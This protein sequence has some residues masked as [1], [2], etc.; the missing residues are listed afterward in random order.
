MRAQQAS[1]SSDRPQGVLTR[2]ARG[3]KLVWGA[4]AAVVGLVGGVLGAAAAWPPWLWPRHLPEPRVYVTAKGVVSGEW[5]APFGADAVPR[6]PSA[7]SSCSQQMESWLSS[8][9][10][11]PTSVFMDAVITTERDE[12]VVILGVRPNIRRISEPRMRTSVTTC[13]PGG[14]NGGYVSRTVEEEVDARPP[15]VRIFGDSDKQIKQIGVN[16]A[17]GDA[18]DLHLVFWAGSPGSVY[19]I[20]PELDILQG[21]EH[22]YLPVPGGPLK[23]A[24]ALSGTAPTVDLQ[25]ERSRT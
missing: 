3:G 6:V 17:K 22:R 19:E 12:S 18:A 21:G 1:E 14:G 9:G 2:L 10:G 4:V 16:L 13:G 23:V 8:V 11:V 15:A 5:V 20:S 24:G 7:V 25:E